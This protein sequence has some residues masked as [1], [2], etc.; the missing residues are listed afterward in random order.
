MHCSWSLLICITVYN[1][2]F[3]G[4]SFGLPTHPCVSIV[5]VTNILVVRRQILDMSI[6]HLPAGEMTITLQDV[7][8]LF[9]LRIDGK[10]VTRTICPN[11]WRERVDVIFQKKK[12]I[13]FDVLDY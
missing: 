5:L 13:G 3:K 9:G 11:G 7:A 6:V 12:K 2:I 10:A 4:S 1:V 8:I